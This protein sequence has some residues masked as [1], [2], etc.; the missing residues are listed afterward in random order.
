MSKLKPGVA[1]LIIPRRTYAECGGGTNKKGLVLGAYDGCNPGELKFT[2][3]AKLFDDKMGG[4]ISALVKGGAGISKGT[5]QVFTNLGDEFYSIAVAGLGEEGAGYNTL[6]ILDECKENIRWAAATGARALQDSGIYNIMVEEFTNAEAAAEGANLAIWQYQDVRSPSEHNPTGKV[7][8]YQ[9]DDRDGWSRGIIKSDCQNFARRLEETPANLMTP[10]IFAQWV[11]DALCPC[12]IQV[13]VRDR[14][15]LEAKKM[16][17]LLTMARG[18]CEE[19]LMLEMGYCGGKPE[20]KPIVF[21][22][23]GVTFDS[24]GICLKQ[25]KGMSDKRGDVA[26]A[27]VCASVL[28]CV[29]QMALPVNVRV[30]TPLMESMIGGSAIKAG[31]VVTAF[32]G[33]TVQIENPDN[34][35]RVMLLEPLAYSMTHLP[36]LLST[37]ASLT[38]T[39]TRGLGCGASAAFST[40]NDVYRELERAGSETGDRVWR[41]P[42]WKYYTDKVTDYP[43][44]DVSNVGKGY[45]ETCKGAAFLREFVDPSLDFLHVDIHG[46]G[47]KV[48]E[49]SFPYLKKGWMSGR[50]TRTLAQFVYQIVCPHDKGDDC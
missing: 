39:T 17:A 45:G 37:I 23:K 40:S 38:G 22:G 34:E 4:K 43:S 15:W 33:K 9:S 47:L 35:G 2:K 8:L 18:S 31:D 3:A 24:G 44:F 11:I 16:S 29:A 10:A 26:G 6:E 27:A 42:F 41:F 19:P 1:S 12:G 32:N 49:S 30:L 21:V 36:C 7:D 20:D 13:E 50:P 48:N 46:T 5:A 28:K 25:C 14:D